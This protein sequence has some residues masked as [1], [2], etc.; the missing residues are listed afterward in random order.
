MTLKPLGERWMKDWTS[1]E[2]EKNTTR[3]TFHPGRRRESPVEKNQTRSRY[4]VLSDFK[5]NEVH[6]ITD[7]Q[8]LA[9]YSTK[10]QN[11]KYF[12]LSR[13]NSPCCNDLALPV[14][15]EQLT[16]VCKRVRSSNKTLFVDTEIRV[17]YNFHEL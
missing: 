14:T 16:A 10:G 7:Y 13:P 2:C 3:V 9:I 15:L 6:N 4:Y 5:H 12:Q 11:L 8:R 17:S 1:V